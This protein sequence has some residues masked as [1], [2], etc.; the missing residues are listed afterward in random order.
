MYELSANTKAI[1]L[2][3]AP[4]LAG[5]N[6]RGESPLSIKEYNQLAS[7]LRSIQHQ[8]ADLLTQRIDEILREIQPFMAEDRIRH[9]LDRG[10]LL[11]QAVE[12]WHNRAIW[13]MSR[14]DTAYPQRLRNRLKENAPPI[15]YGCG[16]ADI[17]GTGG[18][19]VVGSRQADG[20]LIEYTEAVGGLA[21]AARQTV[22][23]GGA[24]GIDQA[25]M[26]GAL[27]V[28]GKVIGVLPDG[29]DNTVLNREFRK[30][31]L[32]RWLVL[33]SPYDP[34]A[35]FNVGHAMQRN[36][37][38]YGLA[39]ASLVVN[40]DLDKGG[41]WAGATEQLEKLNFVRVYVRSTGD[42]GEG[43]KALRAKGAIPWPNPHDTAE[44]VAMLHAPP[45]VK[46]TSGQD[47]LPFTACDV[48]VPRMSSDS[49][50]RSN[51]EAVG[52]TIPSL[53]E[54][55]GPARELFLKVR[56]VVLRLLTRPMSASEVGAVLELNA[57][58]SAE[59]LERLV[60]EGVLERGG[61]EDYVVSS[62]VQQMSTLKVSPRGH[63]R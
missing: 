59:W 62:K 14:A 60:A 52:L 43:L 18:L 13:V 26:R 61:I 55:S 24:K 56:E 6:S 32:D 25:A 10:F 51:H 45:D 7:R 16:D 21:A 29:L 30:P 37:L 42:I 2:L 1:L 33:I 54:D 47:E 36:K 15:L 57:A 44:L 8:P 38:I 12:R 53:D 41:T 19:A 28:P 58:Q 50:Q 34:G 39:D 31:L 4:L 63:P 22:V 3:T 5:R 11:S 9:L 35:S 49:N 17:L 23:S 20:A 27:A 48:R 40:S 46:L